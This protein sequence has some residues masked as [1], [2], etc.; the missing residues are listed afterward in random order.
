MN[1]WKVLGIEQTQE[2]RKIKIAY[3]KL[4]KKIRPDE[5]PKEFAELYEAYKSALEIA[6]SEFEYEVY[7][8]EEQESIN[9]NN[10]ELEENEISVTYLDSNNEFSNLDDVEEKA[11]EKKETYVDNLVFDSLNSLDFNNQNDKQEIELKNEQINISEEEIKLQKNFDENLIYLKK[12]ADSIFSKQLTKIKLDDLKFIETMDLMVNLEFK[13]EASKVIFDSLIKQHSASLNQSVETIENNEITKCLSGFF[14]WGYDWE[15]MWDFAF[16]DEDISLSI[17]NK[18]LDKVF[19][20]VFSRIKVE[21]LVFLEDIGSL[22]NVEFKAYVSKIVFDKLVGFHIRELSPNLVA[23]ELYNT[24]SYLSAFFAWSDNWQ[25]L[26]EYSKE[27]SEREFTEVEDFGQEKQTTDILFAMLDKVLKKKFIK[28]KVSD[29]SAFDRIKK[30]NLILKEQISIRLFKQLL[31]KYNSYL[32]SVDFE[33]FIRYPAIKYLA[34]MFKW[35]RSQYSLTYYKFVNSELY[36]KNY[37][38][39]IASDNTSQSK[40]NLQKLEKIK[41]SISKENVFLV[42]RFFAFSIDIFVIAI[43]TYIIIIYRKYDY[44]M[45]SKL[46]SQMAFSALGYFFVITPIMEANFLQANIGKLIAGVETIDIY[47]QRITGGIAI[48]RSF[49]FLFNIGFIYIYTIIITNKIIPFWL[50]GFIALIVLSVIYSCFEER[51][52]PHDGSTK[53][54]VVL[55]PSFKEIFARFR[56]KN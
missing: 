7:L 49:Y 10:D 48:L 53:T 13:Q 29:F 27:K 9:Q 25:E 19:G 38:N 24:L 17:I 16:Y 33:A 55:S 43:Y 6:E 31:E 26:W 8:N 11:E 15:E 42:R 1:C 45:D 30:D 52:L 46:L 14:N 56:N 50:L 54:K 47:K 39:I 12:E 34:K 28:L 4:L 18:R 21:E 37:K 20:K 3:A 23:V 40:E 22:S 44:N 36:E 32:F 41:K 2:K 51:R 35:Q 5:K